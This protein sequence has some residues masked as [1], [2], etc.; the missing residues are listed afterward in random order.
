MPVVRILTP[1]M[2]SY[3]SKKDT[4]E[5]IFPPGAWEESSH[6]MSGVHPGQD[7]QISAGLPGLL[8]YPVGRNEHVQAVIRIKVGCVTSWSPL[9]LSVASIITSRTINSNL[10]IRFG[11]LCVR[12]LAVPG[13]GDASSN[14]E[15]AQAWECVPVPGFAFCEMPSLSS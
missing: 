1:A 15:V 5:C 2:S 8:F 9:F 11:A 13:R 4:W 7:V 6:L 12:N 14:D 10:D 3:M